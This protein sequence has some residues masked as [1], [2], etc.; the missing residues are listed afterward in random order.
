MF[1]S[2]LYAF[3]TW[4]LP[5]QTDA[6]IQYRLF[7]RTINYIADDIPDVTQKFKYD[8]SGHLIAFIGSDSTNGT[9]LYAQLLD[10]DTEGEV[11][12]IRYFDQNG[13]SRV[14]IY[15][16]QSKELVSVDVDLDAD[17][18]F[19][20]KINE[21]YNETGQLTSFEIDK[22]LYGPMDGNH[23]YIVYYAYDD[24][25]RLLSWHP[26]IPGYNC[27]C[28]TIS[29]NQ[30]DANGRLSMTENITHVWGGVF[31]SV[32]NY[33]VRY[34]YDNDG[35]IAHEYFDGG[36]SGQYDYIATYHFQPT[37]KTLPESVAYKIPTLS[38]IGIFFTGI[39]LLGVVS[40]NF[41]QYPAPPRHYG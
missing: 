15:N 32:T 30:Y 41:R 34:E 13:P 8:E 29:T 39:L 9:L 11:V 1:E 4:G 12:R 40:I 14:D 22:G 26:Y 27:E 24:Q 5:P 31:P 38:D 36:H 6:N 7:E 2:I 33:T 16:R 35:N 21:R 23:E 10:Y 37:T 19:E 20:S 3:L 18:T 28:Y 17:G 25:G